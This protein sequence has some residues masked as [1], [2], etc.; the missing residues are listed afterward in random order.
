MERL[1]KKASKFIAK[2]NTDSAKSLDSSRTENWVYILL[3][4]LVPFGTVI[5]MYLYEGSWTN[6]VTVNL[7]LTFLCGLPGLIH[8]LVVI[9][10]NK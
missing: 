10:G 3:M 1:E 6:R 5:S 7:I 2:M 4:L 8:A 9:F